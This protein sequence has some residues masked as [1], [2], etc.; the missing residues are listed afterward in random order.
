MRFQMN[1]HGLMGFKTFEVC[2]MVVWLLLVYG[3]AQALYSS[4]WFYGMAN[5]DS[6]D[7]FSYM[8]FYADLAKTT[9][10]FGPTI[11]F[12]VRPVDPKRSEVL[13]TNMPPV[14]RTPFT[15]PTGSRPVV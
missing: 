2:A 13:D 9:C 12:T 8:R 3:L 4:L 15:T 1:N 6:R 7:E 11:F 10:C 14:P 5:V